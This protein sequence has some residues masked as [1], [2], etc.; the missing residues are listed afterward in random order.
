MQY[1]IQNWKPK[2]KMPEFLLSGSKILSLAFASVRIIDSINFMPMALSKLPKTFGINEHKKGYFPHFFNIPENQNYIGLYPDISYYG[3]EYMSPE[4]YGT[5]SIWH[6]SKQGEIFD[7]KKELVDYC[8]SDVDILT[9]A[10][11]QFRMRFMDLTGEDPFRKCLTMPSA[12]HLVYR[13][14]FMPSKSIG[15]IPDFGYQQVEASSFKALIW[16]KYISIQANIQIEHSRNGGEKRI[17]RIKLDGWCESTQTAYEFHGCMY[18]GCPKCYT[19]VT[20]NAVL[21]ESMGT[22]YQRH[23]A[24][25]NKLKDMNVTLVEIWECEYDQRLKNDRYF[26]QYVKTQRNI[27][28]PLVPRDALI[29][30][31]LLQAGAISLFYKGRAGYIDFTSLYPYVQSMAYFQ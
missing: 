20:F 31:M 25:I 14:N 6:T 22:T 30:V 9:Q 3:A 27:K 12:C 17:G 5:F 7:F 24:R 16:L 18:H 28:P 23:C 10:C 15:L 2:E 19:D 4:G 13:K 29:G 11:L 8:K 21:H 1:I 26:A